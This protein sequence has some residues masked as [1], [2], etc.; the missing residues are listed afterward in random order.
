MQ[1]VSTDAKVFDLLEKIFCGCQNVLKI[2]EE[3]VLKSEK[4]ENEMVRLVFGRIFW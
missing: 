4:S 3:M 2:W 1:I